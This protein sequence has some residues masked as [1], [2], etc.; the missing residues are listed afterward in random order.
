MV[1][2]TNQIIKPNGQQVEFRGRPN[3]VALSP[4]G[5][6]AAFLNGAYKA[7]ILIDVPSWTVKQEFDAAGS[8]ASFSGIVYSRDGKKLYASQAD[9]HVMIADVVDVDEHGML[10][11]DERVAM[12]LSP[13][14]YP[15]R[16]DGNSYPGGLALSEDGGKLY[17][18]LNRNNTLAM[19][20]L[21][22]RTVVKEIPVG[23]APHDIIVHGDKA[24]VSNRGGRPAEGDDFHPRFER[25]TDGRARAVSLRHDRHRLC[26]RLGGG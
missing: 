25:H 26:G 5:K 2:T 13:I 21:S 17:I 19:M 4:D 20:D 14:P 18:A 1:L 10:A 16:S 7:I 24:Y 11:L 15:G 8:S 12:P 3:A 22:T 23:N 6:T 9:G